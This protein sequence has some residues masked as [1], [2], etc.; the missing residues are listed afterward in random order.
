MANLEQ[1][2][3]PYSGP[4]YD[5]QDSVAQALAGWGA[6]M[7]ADK[8]RAQTLED[9]EL[10]RQAAIE[11]AMAQRGRLPVGGTYDFTPEPV[12]YADE[13]ANTKN[14]LAQRE[15]EDP[16]F[17]MLL[18]GGQGAV[19]DIVGGYTSGDPLSVIANIQSMRTGIGLPKAGSPA[20]K[21]FLGIG[22]APA[23]PRTRTVISTDQNNPGLITEYE[24]SPG[25][26]VWASTPPGGIPKVQP[27]TPS[28]KPKGKRKV[29]YN[30]EEG[31]ID[32]DVDEY[33]PNTMELLD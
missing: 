20:K 2:Q 22:K 5:W 28:V 23:G 9:K 18:K 12:S 33:D 4:Q 29:R 32:F 3:L 24:Q 27:R 1:T 21:G 16:Y 6:G 7:A 26:N 17:S 19:R 10:T 14:Q 25:S 15:L 8:S 11:Q 13:L 30:G 31:E